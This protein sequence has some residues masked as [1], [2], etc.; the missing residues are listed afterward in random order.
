MEEKTAILG[1]RAEPTCQNKWVLSENI[2]FDVG[3]TSVE[4]VLSCQRRSGGS[5]GLRQT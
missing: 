4:F 1:V 3:P 5:E 2:Y